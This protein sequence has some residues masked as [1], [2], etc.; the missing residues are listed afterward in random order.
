MGEWRYNFHV[1]NVADHNRETSRNPEHQFL[2]LTRYDLG[3]SFNLLSGNMGFYLLK[4]G[5]CFL[6]KKAGHE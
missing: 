1:S 6:L 3:H 2:V 4:N 5:L